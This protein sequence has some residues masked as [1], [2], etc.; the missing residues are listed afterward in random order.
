MHGGQALGAVPG[1]RDRPGQLESIHLDHAQI[2]LASHPVAGADREAHTR[3]HEPLDRFGTGKLDAS[4]EKYPA[5][6]QPSL[7]ALLRGRAPLAKD[8]HLTGEQARMHAPASRETMA[9]RC[10]HDDVVVDERLEL[11][12]IG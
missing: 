7:E 12:F 10:V 2:A 4:L 6:C 1:D 9:R 11:K 5:T 3:A 8:E